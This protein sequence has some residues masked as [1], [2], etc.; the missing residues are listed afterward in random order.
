L[1]YYTKN[2][3]SWSIIMGIFKHF[4]LIGL[5]FLIFAAKSVRAQDDGMIPESDMAPGTS[6]PQINSGSPTPPVIIDESDS[7]GASDT[8]DYEN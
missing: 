6:I 7:S 1:R 2:S 3:L 8:D 4:L 5:L